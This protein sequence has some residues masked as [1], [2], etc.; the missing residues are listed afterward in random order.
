VVI[1]EHGC[2]LHSDGGVSCWGPNEM[3]QLGRGIVSPPDVALPAARVAGLQRVTSIAVGGDRA[4]AVTADGQTWCWGGG[5][6]PS[7]APMLCPPEQFTPSSCSKEYS[8]ALEPS[9][10]IACRG[11]YPQPYLSAPDQRQEHDDRGDTSE[12]YTLP[13]PEGIAR[14]ALGP[15][16]LCVTLLNQ[17][18]LCWGEDERG[19][20]GRDAALLEPTP[21]IIQGLDQVTDLKLGARFACARRRDDP[22]DALWCWGQNEDGQLGARTNWHKWARPRRFD[23]GQPIAQ[24]DLGAY[25]ACAVSVEGQGRCWGNLMFNP[26]PDWAALDEHRW[27]GVPDPP[28]W[29]RPPDAGARPTFAASA[30]SVGAQIVC[31]LRAGEGAVYCCDQLSDEPC[32]AVPL[33]APALDLA[34]GSAALS[35]ARLEGGALWCWRH[36]E[37]EAVAVAGVRDVARFAVGDGLCVQREAGQVLCGDDVARLRP[38]EGLEGITALAMAGG[39]ACA[40]TSEGG[41]LCWGLLGERAA[42]RTLPRAR[43]PS[44]IALPGPAAQ[45]AVGETFACARLRDGRVA[46]WGD[47]GSAQLGRSRRYR[48]VELPWRAIFNGDERGVRGHPETAPQ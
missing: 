23:L 13:H 42:R 47:N 34:R 15:E 25:G 17:D 39:Y 27:R 26:T 20:L 4:V 7:S 19:V 22:P 31:A 37:R 44:P 6:A 3:G 12:P 46:C 16:H 48:P 11:D 9:G 8:C 32:R 45:L 18:I 35:C 10:H 30:L 5:K 21:Q 24:L 40:L 43:T 33:P 36:D 41:A 28:R 38:V 2:A 1:D 14:V 29:R